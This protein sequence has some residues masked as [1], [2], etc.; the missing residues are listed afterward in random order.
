MKFVN[1][2]LGLGRETKVSLGQNLG[3]IS[4]PEYYLRRIKPHTKQK[5]K[6]LIRDLNEAFFNKFTVPF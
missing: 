1:F 2:C 6:K 5:K 4:F 3:Q